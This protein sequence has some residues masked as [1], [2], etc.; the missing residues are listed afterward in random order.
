MAEC[1]QDAG[2]HSEGDVWTH[3]KLVCAQLPQL[4]GWATLTPRE[5]TVLLLTALFHECAIGGRVSSQGRISGRYSRLIG[6]RRGELCW[7]ATDQRRML[8]P[9]V[10]A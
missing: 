2:W 9:G 10:I 7:T 8:E 3:T 1:R 4:E 5:R 6:W